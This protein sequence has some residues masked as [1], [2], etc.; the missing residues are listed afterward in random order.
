[1][2][3][4]LG[5]LGPFTHVANLYT[6]AVADRCVQSARNRLVMPIL[7]VAELYR[8]PAR[9]FEMTTRKTWH[10][11]NHWPYF[12][13][14]SRHTCSGLS[15]FLTTCCTST[16]VSGG[17]GTSS[18]LVPLFIG[19]RK[20]SDW[21]IDDHVTVDLCLFDV[22][23]KFQREFKAECIPSYHMILSH[24]DRFPACSMHSRERATRL[25]SGHV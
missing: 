21:L 7:L 8:S 2:P 22:T 12:V 6:H 17:P 11:Q 18:S 19:H 4:Y 3:G 14:S 15:L 9:R 13:A 1:M 16:D 10:Q 5:G 25:D 23:Y 20:S 24:N